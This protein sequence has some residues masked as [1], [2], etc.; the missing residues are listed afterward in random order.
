MQVQVIVGTSAGGRSLV[1][2]HVD[3]GARTRIQAVAD[4]VYLV[5]SDMRVTKRSDILITTGGEPTIV[6]VTPSMVAGQE[7]V[8]AVFQD[9]PGMVLTAIYKLRSIPSHRTQGQTAA[10]ARRSCSK[11][12]R[13]SRHTENP[14]SQ[15]MQGVRR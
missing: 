11:R 7:H 13:R 3:S 14:I 2:V 10:D 8:A 6:D 15:S 4:V 9:E 12:P 1:T 5:E